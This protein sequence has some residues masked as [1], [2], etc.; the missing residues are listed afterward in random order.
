MMEA[1]VVDASVAIKWLVEELGSDRARV[2]SRVRLEAPDLLLIEVREY[3][4]EEGANRR[5]HEEA[6]EREPDGAG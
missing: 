4:M 1:A 3:L 2:L 5:P 6:G